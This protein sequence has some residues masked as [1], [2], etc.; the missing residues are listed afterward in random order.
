MHYPAIITDESTHILVTFP[1]CPGC[2]AFASVNDNILELAQGALIEWL[3][4]HLE[5]GGAPPQPSKEITVSGAARPLVV[6]V[7][8]ELARA[9]EARWQWT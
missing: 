4:D 9:L 2:Q 3:R 5:D 8:D 1:D 6:P 7:P